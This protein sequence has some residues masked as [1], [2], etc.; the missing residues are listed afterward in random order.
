M[1]ER[2]KSKKALWKN[3]HFKF[4]ETKEKASNCFAWPMSELI[5]G[6][7]PC[8]SVKHVQAQLFSRPCDNCSHVARALACIDFSAWKKLIWVSMLNDYKMRWGKLHTQDR[9]PL[10]A[11]NKESSCAARAIGRMDSWGVKINEVR[12]TTETRL[13]WFWR[14]S[15]IL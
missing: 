11:Q 15:N 5:S 8:V 14:C 1:Q 9:S 13:D 10:T 12:W 3:L 2:K 6:H 7:V 4:R